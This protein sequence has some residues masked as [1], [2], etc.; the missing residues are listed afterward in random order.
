MLILAECANQGLM[1]KLP[2][3]S[4]DLHVG[5]KELSRYLSTELKALGLVG[6]DRRAR[7]VQSLES[8]VKERYS[9]PESEP[10]PE[11][12]PSEAP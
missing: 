11:S 2:D 8:Y 9:K 4:W 12:T 7:P 3:G 10:V 1:R 6:L 5:A